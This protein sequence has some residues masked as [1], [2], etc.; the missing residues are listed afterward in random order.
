MRSTGDKVESACTRIFNR[1]T[2]RRVVPFPAQE[3]KSVPALIDILQ[4]LWQLP[5]AVPHFQRSLG[6]KGEKKKNNVLSIAWCG[7]PEAARATWPWRWRHEDSRCSHASHPRQTPAC[8]SPHAL[9]ASFQPSCWP[10]PSAQV[11]TVAWCRSSYT[12]VCSEFNGK[13][14]FK[15]PPHVGS[16]LPGALCSPSTCRLQPGM[17]GLELDGW[18]SAET[19]GS[20]LPRGCR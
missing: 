1:G 12:V 7:C 10:L 4:T 17:E 5:G 19:N 11:A 15:M 16:F 18:R 9:F 8:L 20:L 6:N 3:K 13:F 2:S 14:A